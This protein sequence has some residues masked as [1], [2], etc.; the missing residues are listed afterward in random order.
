[1]H[2]QIVVGIPNVKIHRNLA[3]YV[4]VLNAEA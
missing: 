4:I 3:A 2:L 1:M